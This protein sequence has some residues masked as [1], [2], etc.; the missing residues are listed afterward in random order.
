MTRKE[1]HKLKER[2]DDR[3]SLQTATSDSIEEKET[4]AGFQRSV[5]E[6]IE[7]NR[8]AKV[9]DPANHLAKFLHFVA[10]GNAWA[11]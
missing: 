4:I 7:Q 10:D 9:D 2:P 1:W 8:L 5:K 6:Y 11:D 3:A